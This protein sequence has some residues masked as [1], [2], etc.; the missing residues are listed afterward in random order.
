MNKAFTSPQAR[1]PSVDRVLRLPAV[2][3]LIDAYGR[4]AVTDAV[5]AVQDHLRAAMGAGAAV[6][7]DENAVARQGAAA[8]AAAARP[9]LR[10]V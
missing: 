5:R 7:A 3:A 9:T 10:P 2:E 8:L 4:P 6:A 1:I